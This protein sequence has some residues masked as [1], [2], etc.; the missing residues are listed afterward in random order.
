MIKLFSQFEHVLIATPFALSEEGK[1]S[2][3]MALEQVAN[4]FPSS[5]RTAGASTITM[6]PGL[7]HQY[8]S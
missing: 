7:A 4:E 1:I 2:D 8:V 5:Y 6:E 3:G